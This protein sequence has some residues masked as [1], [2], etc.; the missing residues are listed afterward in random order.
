MKS[1]KKSKLRFSKADLAIF[2][3]KTCDTCKHW[4]HAEDFIGVDG[5][6]DPWMVCDHPRLLKFERP[7]KDGASLMDGSYYKAVLHTG[8]KF[9]CVHHESK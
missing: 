2:N 7:D 6:D 1:P 9:G 8:P 3:R 4:K 5:S